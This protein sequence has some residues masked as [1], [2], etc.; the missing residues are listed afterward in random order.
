MTDTYVHAALADHLE[1]PTL[2]QEI[3]ALPPAG[4]HAVNELLASV[5]DLTESGVD[6]ILRRVIHRAFERSMAEFFS[7]EAATSVQLPTELVRY[8]QPAPVALPLPRDTGTED[9]SLREAL[10]T[11]RSRRNYANRP[12]TLDELGSLLGIALARNAVEDG[13]GTRDIPQ[14]PYPSIGGLD[15]VEVGVIVQSVD[16]V[17]PGY[18]TY[19]KV[20]HGLV[21]VTHGDFRLP[22]MDA[23]FENEW[24]FYAPV[25]LVIANDQ[26][27]VSWKYK[28]RGYRI[29][30]MDLGAA[31]QNLYLA[32]TALNLSCCAVAGYH[33]E[34]I[35][36]LLGYPAGDVSVGCLVPIGS[37]PESGAAG[38]R[39]R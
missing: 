31:I 22:L 2:E 36:A 33:D 1:E 20:G 28:T 7:E 38:V 12:M 29:S 17:E 21:T 37:T 30:F 34:L 13:Y 15:P 23:T 25:V 5:R 3:A 27:K 6:P 14:F 26:R 11:R 19:D 8:T 4:R 10:A 9:L 18:Y 32:S 35:N 24:I 39:Q 16:G